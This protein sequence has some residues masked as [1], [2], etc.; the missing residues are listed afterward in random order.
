MKIVK[1]MLGVA[2]VTAGVWMVVPSVCSA[3][4]TGA[5][6]AAAAAV[7]PGLFVKSAP[8]GGKSL[9][10]V[11]AS[12]KA[13]DD[14]TVKGRVAPG[15]QAFAEGTATVSIIEPGKSGERAVVRAVD[16]SGGAIAAN[17][18]NQ[19]GLMPGVEVVVQGRLV[20]AD[21]GKPMVIEAKRIYAEPTGMP[22]GFFL[23]AEP[24]GSKFVEEVK[25]GAKKG[26]TV[27]VRGRIG[28]SLEPFVGG[29]AVFTIVGPGIKSCADEPDDPC[30]TPW[31][32]CCE[33]KSDIVL[34]S[35]SV[36]VM[37]KSNKLMKMGMKGR[38]GLEELTDVS[39]VG[40]VTFADGKAMV[41][42]ATGVYVHPVG[43]S[44]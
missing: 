18:A 6:G 10:E 24:E 28:G 39:V 3:Q 43:E 5:G 31:D 16:A 14:V 26:D 19:G 20:G 32:Y 12:A 34:H 9:S 17:L 11:R 37:D 23:A 41:V 44:K 4:Q 13:G 29:R 27:V 38:G 15:N 30:K 42:Q 21:A 40:K 7:P 36:Q 35:A 33:T 1:S 22:D 25:K 2:V 8:E